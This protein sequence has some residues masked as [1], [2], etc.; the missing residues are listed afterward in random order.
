MLC[1]AVL[2]SL[3]IQPLALASGLVQKA[4][5]REKSLLVQAAL[6]LDHLTL[7]NNTEILKGYFITRACMRY[8]FEQLHAALHSDIARLTCIVKGRTINDKNGCTF[9]KMNSK[10]KAMKNKPGSAG[11]CDLLQTPK[12]RTQ[13]AVTYAAW[14]WPAGASALCDRAVWNKADQ[15]RMTQ[16]RAAQRRLISSH[17]PLMQQ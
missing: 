11:V 13:S 10:I 1:C 9:N 5:A 16:Q 2:T 14:L 15:R 4:V 17:L 8:K 12:D 7:Q 6:I 3:S